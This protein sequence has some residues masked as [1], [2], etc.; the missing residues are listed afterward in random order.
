[1]YF[2]L[3]SSYRAFLQSLR[4]HSTKWSE[5]RLLHLHPEEKWHSASGRQVKYEILSFELWYLKYLQQTLK[6]E[7]RAAEIEKDLDTLDSKLTDMAALLDPLKFARE[8]EANLLNEVAYI[9]YRIENIK[10]ELKGCDEEVY[11]FH[12][13]PNCIHELC[14]SF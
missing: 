2:N 14:D 7:E 5:W 1:M 13:Y 3:A 11:H 12:L 6:L 8:A 9:I 10:E 4:G